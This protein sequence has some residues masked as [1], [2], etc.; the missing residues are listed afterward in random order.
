MI[1]ALIIEDEKPAARRLQRMLTKENIDVLETLN[2]VNSAVAWLQSNPQPPLVFCDIQLSDGIAFEIFE[3]I[4]I[5]SPIIFTTAYDEYA[6]RAFKLNSIDYLLKPFTQEDLQFAIQKYKNTH[7]KNQVENFSEVFKNLT[8]QKIY[9]ERFLVRKGV[10]IQVLTTRDIDYFYS[11]NKM[12]YIHQYSGKESI[13]DESLEKLTQIIDPEKF[14]RVNRQ[15]IINR[16]AVKEMIRLANKRIKLVLLSDNMEVI[17]ARERV[18]D[19]L[20][21]I[22]H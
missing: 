15:Y 16:E 8:Q 2:S 20:K 9:K 18:N 17:V 14:F 6:I 11:E 10:Y 19:F 7:S 5:N 22:V 13:V 1:A 21:W 3:K 4:K 12:T